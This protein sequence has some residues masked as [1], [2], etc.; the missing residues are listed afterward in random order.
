MEAEARAL[1]EQHGLAWVRPTLDNYAS[2]E[3]TTGLT[4]LVSEPAPLSDDV[5]AQLEALDA[6]YDEQAAILGDEDS[7]DDAIAAAETEIER[8]DHES[9][10]IRDRPQVIAPELRPQ[11]GMI[12]TLGRDGARAAAGIL[13]RRGAAA[14]RRGRRWCRG[15]HGKGRSRSAPIGAEAARR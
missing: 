1:A 10:A 14:R 4:R 13:R 6:A 2:H 12:L 7:D 15:R 3:L 11:A 8:I 9:R 5:I